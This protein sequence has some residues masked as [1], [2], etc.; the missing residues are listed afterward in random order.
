MKDNKGKPKEGLKEKVVNWLKG[1]LNGDKN[2]SDE[3]KGLFDGIKKKFTWLVSLIGGD[4]VEKVISKHEKVHAGQI[5]IKWSKFARKHLGSLSIEDKKRFGILEGEEKLVEKFIFKIS[6]N[7]K[8]GKKTVKNLYK[9][10]AL[11]WRH[12]GDKIVKEKGDLVEDLGSYILKLKLLS[13][14]EKKEDV[15]SFLYA[16]EEICMSVY[17]NLNLD[18]FR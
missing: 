15:S 7:G 17:T 2:K 8:E 16:F 18:K 6:N 5:M 3:N 12:K 10:F 13:E 4:K 14:K 11:N 9:Y 1:L